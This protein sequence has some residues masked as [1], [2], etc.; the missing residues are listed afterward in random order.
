MI[1]NNYNIK[2]E[3]MHATE[4]RTRT[5]SRRVITWLQSLQ[6]KIR[7]RIDDGGSDIKIAVDFNTPDTETL[8]HAI[9]QQG[10]VVE[11]DERDDTVLIIRW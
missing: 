9:K 3:L 11:R 2:D 10:Y 6:R 1:E 7:L 8:L 5:N 4:A